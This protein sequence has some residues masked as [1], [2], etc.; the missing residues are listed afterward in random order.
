MGKISIGLTALALIVTATQ[1]GPTWAASACKRTVTH[2]AYQSTY[3]GA[4][5]CSS[6]CGCSCD[7]W[8]CPPGIVGGPKVSCHPDPCQFPKS[9]PKYPNQRPG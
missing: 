5:F 9:K 6:A 4:Y 8:Q 2:V 7:V 1:A 3:L